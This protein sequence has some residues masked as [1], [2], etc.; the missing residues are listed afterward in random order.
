MLEKMVYG[1][2][3]LK[4][5]YE[6]INKYIDFIE[7]CKNKE[8]IIIKNI[9]INNKELENFGYL[10]R[11]DCFDMV[12]N[13]NE[14]SLILSNEKTKEQIDNYIKSLSKFYNV[15]STKLNKKLLSLDEIKTDNAFQIIPNKN[16]NKLEKDCITLLSISA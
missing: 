7:I 5:K 3:L 2:N 1:K 14:Q 15:K 16:K 13:I 12:L 10:F 11:N 6:L 9:K 8:E 4:N